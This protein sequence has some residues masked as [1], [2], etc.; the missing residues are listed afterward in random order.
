MDTQPNPNLLDTGEAA[1]YLRLSTQFL[2]KA[3]IASNTG[4]RFVKLGR[5]VFYRRDDL[6]AWIDAQARTSTSAREVA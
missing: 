4:P 6:D 5:R 3:R 2:E 1:S